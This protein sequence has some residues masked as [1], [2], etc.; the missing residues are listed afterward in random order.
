MASDTG[1]PP[2]VPAEL[3]PF[4]SRY[5]TIDGNRIHYVDE[6]SGPTILFLHGNPTWSFL[7][8]N[9]IADLRDSFRCIA[10][11]YPGFGLSAASESYGSKVADHAA[12]VERFVLDL[13]LDDV[14]LMGQDWGGPIGLTVA[15]RHPERFGGFIFGNTWAWPLN[16]ILH[17]EIAARMMGNRV[18]G[19][20]IRN[21]NAF[22]NVMIP[23]GTATKVDDV[24]MDAYRAPF[25]TRDARRPMWEFPRELLRSEHFMKRLEADVPRVADVPVLFVWGGRDF[26]LRERVELPR[27]QRMF[28]NHRTVILDGAKH[29]FQ[30]DAPAEAVRSIRAWMASRRNLPVSVPDHG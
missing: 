12:V 10:L 22:V 30:E 4:E 25:A 29:F 27:L 9:F 6:G 23:L 17:F 5:V 19:F 26:A 2:W 11:D 7:Y 3:Y 21:A 14:T 28:P 24:V 1:R 16:G 15:T 13:D 20:W 18:A 8:R